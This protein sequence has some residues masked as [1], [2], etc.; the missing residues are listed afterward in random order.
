MIEPGVRSTFSCWFPPSSAYSLSA[1]VHTLSLSILSYLYIG[2]VIVRV[3]ARFVSQEAVQRGV[4]SLAFGLYIDRWL[5]RW[6][7]TISG[8]KGHEIRADKPRIGYGRREC[9]WEKGRLRTGGNIELQ[10]ND[11]Q[12]AMEVRTL[13]TPNLFECS[14][15]SSIFFLPSIVFPLFLQE[16]A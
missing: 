13:I 9:V 5:M 3:G 7:W 2:A 10:K 14:L 12:R 6:R 8:R 1:V 11:F 16:F 15:Y 4:W